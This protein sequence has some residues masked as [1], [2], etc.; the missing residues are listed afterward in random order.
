MQDRWIIGF[1]SLVLLLGSSL[2]ES[3][4][5]PEGA[6]VPA[7]R[8]LDRNVYGEKDKRIGEVE[9]III[10]RSGKVK[11]LTVQFDEWFW[12]IGGKRVA[13]PF[14]KFKMENGNIALD[15]TQKQLEERPMF[16]YYSHGLRPGYYYR[17]RRCRPYAGYYRYPPPGYYYGPDHRPTPPIEDW[18]YSPARYLASG[19]MDRRLINEKGVQIGWVKDLLINSKRNEVEKIIV[20]SRD[21]LGEGTHVALPFVPLGFTVY[22]LVWDI[23]PAELKELPTYSYEEY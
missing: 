10:R 15:V 4:A 19:V 20:S 11:K 16:D 1:L 23:S 17:Y 13:L 18:A 3:Q 5:H 12:D 21:I 6:S 2:I 8:I 22:G 9:D 14:K 7:S